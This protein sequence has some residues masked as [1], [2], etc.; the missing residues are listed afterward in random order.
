MA[1]ETPER[2]LRTVGYYA[3]VHRIGMLHASCVLP[4]SRL[5]LYAFN[6]G[7]GKEWKEPLVSVLATCRCI[8]IMQRKLKH[9]Y[10]INM[11]SERDHMNIYRQGRVTVT[12][13]GHAPLRS[14]SSLGPYKIA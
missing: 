4:E 10:M 8:S 1:Q 14:I 5:G 9:L 11:I 12:S 2:S 3:G 7:S 6:A 13:S